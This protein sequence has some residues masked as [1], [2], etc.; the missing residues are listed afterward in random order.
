M[1][2]RLKT[3]LAT[4]KLPAAAAIEGHR[5]SPGDPMITSASPDQPARLPRPFHWQELE[6]VVLLMI[7]INMPVI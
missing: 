3:E 4:G 1:D 7:I 6:G 2:L 5:Q